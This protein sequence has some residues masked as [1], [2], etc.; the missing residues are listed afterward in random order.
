M[1]DQNGF[2]RDFYLARY[3]DITRAG[4]D[5]YQHFIQYGW[6]EGRNPNL[7]FD[8]GFYLRNNQDVARAGMNPLEHYMKFGWK[9][10]RDP[11]AA[12][13]TSDYLAV[14][15]DVAAAGMNPLQHYLQYGAAEKRPLA[16]NSNQELTEGFDRVY[17]LAANPDVAKAGIDPYIHYVQ[18][19]EAEGRKPDALFDKAFYLARNPDVARA[20]VNALEHFMT[21]GWKEGRDPSATFSLARFRAAN[22]DLGSQNPLADYLAGEVKVRADMAYLDKTGGGIIRNRADLSG[23]AFINSATITYTGT[24]A[25]VSSALAA[26][27]GRTLSSY[28]YAY[29]DR[30][31]GNITI[32]GSGTL[33]ELLRLGAG[34]DSITGTFSGNVDLSAGTGLLSI[35]ATFNQGTVLIDAIQATSTITIAGDA[36][37]SFKGGAGNDTVRLGPADDHLSGGAGANLLDGGAGNDVAYWTGEVRADLLTGRAVSLGSGTGFSDTLVSIE[38]LGGSTGNDILLG[39]NT[40]NVI[41]GDFTSSGAEG[42]NDFLAGR[43]GNDTLW[44]DAGNDTLI[45][46]SGRDVLL[47]GAGDDLLIDRLD[48]DP[49]GWIME[50]GEGNDRLVVQLGPLVPWESPL[51]LRG[52]AGADT[53]IIDPSTGRY[54]TISPDFKQAEG[55]RIDL[56]ALRTLGGQVVTLADVK[57]AASPWTTGTSIDLSAFKDS[58]GNTLA[59]A[60]RLDSVASASNL[61][62]ADFIFTATSDWHTSVPGEFLPLI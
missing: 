53:F 44:G 25:K 30:S 61:S 33:P 9:E 21:Y 39:D 34:D 57:A 51:A 8:T 37:V 11:S 4:V 35:N 28:R 38:N 52:G 15:V 22:P 41:T 59:G 12:F 5:P 2:D 50:G 49:V 18:F 48:I 47:G 58:Q 13:D 32:T 1:I 26:I 54:G 43:G 27:D 40:A 55:D 24:D 46:G 6:Q 60:I 29:F 17:Y 36:N 3:P 20:G 19:G 31:I 56:S 45:G 42:G 14:N 62:A 23:Y 16:A 7:G 10:G